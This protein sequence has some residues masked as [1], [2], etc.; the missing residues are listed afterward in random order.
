MSVR[1]TEVRKVRAVVDSIKP[2]GL[3]GHVPL[4]RYG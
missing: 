1:G 2:T 3:R 4:D